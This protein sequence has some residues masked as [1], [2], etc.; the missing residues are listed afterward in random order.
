LDCALGF[1]QILITPEERCKT[2]LS[3]PTGHLEY[4]R[5]PFGLKA[6][7]A[8]FQRMMNYILRESI[9]ERCLVYMDDVLV[10]GKMLEEH[11]MK[12]R[13]VFSQFRKYRIKIEPDKREFLKPQI[14]YLGHVFTA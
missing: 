6:A 3:T 5:M 10:T 9:R 13:E 7:S 2:V 4:F 12:L 1:H 8:T 14:A 11:Y